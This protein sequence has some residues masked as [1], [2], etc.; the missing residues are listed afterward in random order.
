MSRFIAILLVSWAMLSEGYPADGW[1]PAMFPGYNCSNHEVEAGHGC[2]ANGQ[3]KFTCAAARVTV[4]QYNWTE[5]RRIG[6][7]VS[8]D[9][10]FRCV[11]CPKW[12]WPESYFSQ[13]KC[14]VAS[15]CDVEAVRQSCYDPRVHIFS[16]ASSACAHVATCVV[17]VLSGTWLL[18]GH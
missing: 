6:R 1:S 5:S 12:Q 11:W 4:T 10:A 16:A 13:D 8:R 2:S 14:L 15:S 18:F 9:Y 7:N 17:A 3:N